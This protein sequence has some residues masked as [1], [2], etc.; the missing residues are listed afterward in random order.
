MKQNDHHTL[1]YSLISV[2]IHEFLKDYHEVWLVLLYLKELTHFH[3]YKFKYAYRWRMTV[4]W[5]EDI[6]V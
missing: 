6:D 4:S 5:V 2:Q 1:F 3:I